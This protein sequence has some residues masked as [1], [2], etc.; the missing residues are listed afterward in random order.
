MT[1]IYSLFH[2]YKQEDGRNEIKH[3]GLVDK[4]EKAYDVFDRLKKQPGFK[5]HPDGFFI[6]QLDINRSSAPL[7]GINFLV[8]FSQRFED[9]N[10]AIL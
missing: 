8:G 4:K 5:L 1:V 10:V 2:V 9:N 6:D 7:L 3:I